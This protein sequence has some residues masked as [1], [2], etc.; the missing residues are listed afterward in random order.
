MHIS[1][2]RWDPEFRNK[3]LSRTL[4][5]KDQLDK[6]FCQI[7]EGASDRKAQR[8]IS[9]V[10]TYLVQKSMDGKTYTEDDVPMLYDELNVDLKHIPIA[11]QT[12]RYFQ[13]GAYLKGRK[14]IHAIATDAVS[15]EADGFS[16]AYYYFKCAFIFER[17]HIDCA[18]KDMANLFKEYDISPI[19]TRSIMKSLGLP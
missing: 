18:L 9:D 17:D 16:R 4:R 12:L 3:E 7:K 5:G 11:F 6:M 1:K 10:M 19:K 15:K 8:V 13:R 2:Y 14:L